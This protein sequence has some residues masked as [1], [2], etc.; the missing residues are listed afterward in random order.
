MF[1]I[2]NFRNCH[3]VI[4][5]SFFRLD[6]SKFIR[7][8]YYTAMIKA[9]LISNYPSTL[10]NIIDFKDRVTSSA[11]FLKQQPTPWSLSIHTCQLIYGRIHQLKDRKNVYGNAVMESKNV[12]LKITHTHSFT[13]P[14]SFCC[15]SAIWNIF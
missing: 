1:F 13:Q 6:H 8:K 10:E 2:P 14:L 11:F 4:K 5:I 3:Y 12:F 7:I 15:N 9:T